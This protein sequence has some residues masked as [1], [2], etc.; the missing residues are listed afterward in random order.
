MAVK[1]SECLTCLSIHILILT[2]PKNLT[3]KF[4]TFTMENKLMKQ[5]TGGLY[6]FRTGNHN[7]SYN[8]HERSRN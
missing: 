5:I 6:H 7:A 8:G 2:W 3:K 1:E 4:S